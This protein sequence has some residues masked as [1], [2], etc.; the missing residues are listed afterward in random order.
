MN[1]FPSQCFTPA[2]VYCS[3]P[4]PPSPPPLFISKDKAATT[5]QKIFR[6]HLE[7]KTFLP[8]SLFPLYA[9][10][11]ANTE[12]KFMFMATDGK[13]PVYLPEDLPEVVLKKSGRKK[14]IFRFHQTQ[15]VRSILKSEKCSHLIIPKVKLYGEFLIE[16]RLP[17]DTCDQHNVNLYE[18]N[19]D[20]FNEPVR[21]MVRLFSKSHIPCLTSWQFDKNTNTT[22]VEDTRYDNLPFY[23][24]NKNGKQQAMIGLIDL[25]RAGTDEKASNEHRLFT[26]T[27]IFPY[28]KNIIENEADKL[29]MHFNPKNIESASRIGLKYLTKIQALPIAGSSGRSFLPKGTFKEKKY[30][31]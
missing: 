11:C 9:Q 20:L 29:S 14:A 24:T 10:Q 21:E 4:F 7:K 26:L 18:R 27:V 19:R 12:T 28:H 5:I 31:T 17:I 2:T 25:E 22:Y 8:R 1:K 6:G 13:T 3:T 23:L 30:P 15:K 16:E